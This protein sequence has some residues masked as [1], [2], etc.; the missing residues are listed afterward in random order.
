MKKEKDNGFIKRWE[1]AKYHKLFKDS[2]FLK[3]WTNKSPKQYVYS[4][5][6]FLLKSFKSERK[7]TG[8]SKLLRI[9]HHE[10]II[11]EKKRS[12]INYKQL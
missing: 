9:F 8:V 5:L 3:L 6:I 2:L 7:Y 12:K 10:E 4:T 1:R 11:K